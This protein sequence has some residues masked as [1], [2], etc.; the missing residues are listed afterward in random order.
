M[1]K[2][3]K[4]FENKRKWF[5]FTADGYILC[6]HKYVEISIKGLKYESKSEEFDLV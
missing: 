1:N 2:I 5:A 3:S 4:W 6:A